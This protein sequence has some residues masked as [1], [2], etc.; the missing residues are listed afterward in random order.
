[1]CD[2]IV[3]DIFKTVGNT[4]NKFCFPTNQTQ[5]TSPVCLGCH[6]P[7][8]GSY[9]C[10]RC[11]WPICSNGESCSQSPLHFSTGECAVLSRCSFKPIIREDSKTVELPI[12]E[13]LTPFRCILAKKFSPQNWDVLTRMEQHKE[14]RMKDSFY[15]GKK[16]SEYKFRFS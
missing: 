4:N 8:D 9:R 5:F 15:L 10:E 3:W 12:Y 13:C 2:L 11:S 14:E 7:V 6:K 16:W 1:M